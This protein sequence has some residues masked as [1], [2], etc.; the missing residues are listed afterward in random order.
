MGAHTAFIRL[1]RG[2]HVRC[3]KWVRGQRKWGWHRTQS[4]QLGVLTRVSFPLRSFWLARCAPAGSECLKCFQNA[5][6]VPTTRGT[7]PPDSAYLGSRNQCDFGYD[8]VKPGL[9]R[10]ILAVSPSQSP[11]VSHRTGICGCAD[12][13]VYL[14]C[15]N[16]TRTTRNDNPETARPT[17]HASQT[18][19]CSR[20]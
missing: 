2:S 3:R 8:T 18:I 4:M 7:I 16:Q 20:S 12:P 19:H 6:Y 1:A 15:S 14:Y 17:S 10:E 11:F 9:L 5:Y 13:M